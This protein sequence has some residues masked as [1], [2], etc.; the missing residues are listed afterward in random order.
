MALGTLPSLTEINTELSQTG[1]SLASCIAIAGKTGVFTK[2]SD[3]ANYYKPRKSVSMT[4]GSSSTSTGACSLI[5]TYITLYFEGASAWPAIGDTVYVGDE[6]GVDDGY[7]GGSAWHRGETASAVYQIYK[8][9]DVLDK[10]T[11]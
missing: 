9:G 8:N 4:N 10:A 3:F 11:C 5:P 1:Q 7:D 2:Q 6:P